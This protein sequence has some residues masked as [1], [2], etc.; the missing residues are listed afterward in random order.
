MDREMK[1]HYTLLVDF[2]GKILGP[3]Y[4]VALHELLDDSNEIIAIANG[5]LTGRHLGSPLSNKMLE[6]LTSRLYETQDYVLRFESTSV[7]GKKLCSNSL[8]IKD[9]HGRLVGLLCINF[10]SSRY[11][12]LSARVMDLCGSLLTPGAPSGTHLI[13]ENDEHTYPSS[14][15]GAT[16]SIRLLRHC[17]LSRAGGPSDAGRKDGDHGCAEPQ[18]RVPAEGLR[19]PCGTGAPQLRGQHLPLSGQAQQ[20]GLTVKIGRDGCAVPPENFPFAAFPPI[21]GKFFRHCCKYHGYLAAGVV[22]YRQIEIEK[23]I[24]T[25]AIVHANAQTFPQEVLQSNETVLVDFWAA[26]CGPCKMLAPIL[27]ELDGVAPCKIVKVDVDEN[28]ALALQYAVA[29]I[30]TLLVFRNGQL[31]NRSVG[32]ISREDVLKLVQA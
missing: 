29:S 16:A 2:L 30:P 5:E 4:E 20:Q 3:D 23:E 21:S 11:R 6:F 25:M 17:G 19:E 13:V 15:A 14:I 27:E 31:V 8:F 24:L 32:L 18:G 1:R 22:Y 26:W 28:R 10:D 7:T 12:E 9:P